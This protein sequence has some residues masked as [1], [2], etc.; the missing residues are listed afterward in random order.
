M[1]KF[2]TSPNM[3]GFNEI[4]VNI[5]AEIIIKGIESLIKKR[6]LNFTLSDLVIVVEGFEDPFSCSMIK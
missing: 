3:L 2:S 6:G 5:R 4:S 1:L